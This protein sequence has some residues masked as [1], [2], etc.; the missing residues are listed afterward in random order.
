MHKPTKHSGAARISLREKKELLKDAAIRVLA[1]HGVEGASTRNIASSAKQNVASIHYAFD[2]KDQLLMS[3]PEVLQ[4]DV[5][6]V[7]GESVQH[8]SDARSAISCMAIAYLDHCIS[9]PD[10]QRVHYELT[11]FSLSKTDYK[12]V[13]KQQYL[14]YQDVLALVLYN[15]LKDEMPQ[16]EIANLAVV[17]LALIDGIIIQYLAVRDEEASKKALD[18]G[19]RAMQNMCP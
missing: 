19:I 12:E 11:L 6:E 2:S 14:E 9:D 8:C 1:K 7:L 4:A 5:K 18:L 17:C 3:I 10:L 15:F 13:A 16:E